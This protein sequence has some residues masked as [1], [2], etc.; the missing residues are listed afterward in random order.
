MLVN[1]SNPQAASGFTKE[2]PV[3]TNKELPAVAV[4]ANAVE[5]A[6]DDAA[7]VVQLTP[8]ASSVA[9]QAKSSL[10][11][12]PMVDGELVAAVKAA[13]ARGEIP[14]DLAKLADAIAEHHGVR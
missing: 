14:L 1:F 5:P 4:A 11:E 3:V 2:S 13:L 12:M 7:S 8:E 9:S 10:A 6:V